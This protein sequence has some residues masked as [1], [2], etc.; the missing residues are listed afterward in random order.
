M[1][2]PARFV[3]V[4]KLCFRRSIPTVHAWLERRRQFVA[5]D[6][7]TIGQRL[8][9]HGFV[10]RL[11]LKTAYGHIA[12]VHADDVATLPVLGKVQI[13]IRLTGQNAAQGQR[14][15]AVSIESVRALQLLA[16]DLTT[17]A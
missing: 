5:R 2:R 17:A 6:S 16:P 15:G 7:I 12:L 4:E 3:S 14:A 8:S 1:L 10:L 11:S 9:G 13:P